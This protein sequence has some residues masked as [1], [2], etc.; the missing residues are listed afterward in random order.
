[1]VLRFEFL[2]RAM[3]KHARKTKKLMWINKETI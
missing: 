3:A 1:M 2:V